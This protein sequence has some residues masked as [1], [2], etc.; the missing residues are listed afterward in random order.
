MLFYVSFI[1]YDANEQA[2]HR[3]DHR[4][5]FQ[6]SL[7]IV[8]IVVVFLRFEHFWRRFSAIFVL[9]LGWTPETE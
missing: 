4:E 5:K 9:I 7:F 6:I 1:I 8:Q 3:E 2:D